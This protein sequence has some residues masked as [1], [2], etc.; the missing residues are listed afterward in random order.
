MARKESDTKRQK[1]QNVYIL[2]EVETLYYVM[3]N[4]VDEYKVCIYF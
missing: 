3:E 4:D 1:R 2:C